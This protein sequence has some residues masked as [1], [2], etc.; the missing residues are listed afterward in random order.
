M[1]Y[2]KKIMSSR[3]LGSLF[4]ILSGTISSYAQYTISG[5]VRDSETR[6][7]LPY[8]SLQ[9]QGT[10]HGT[11][12][13]EQGNFSLTLKENP[14]QAKLIVSFIG[15]TAATLILT[16][17]QKKYIILLNPDASALKEVV[18]VSG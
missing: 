6:E 7:S 2:N 3:I 18:V 5:T 1:R 13:N 15:Y 11:T 10:T 16:G 12:S 9:I 8:A 17:N 14:T 4:I